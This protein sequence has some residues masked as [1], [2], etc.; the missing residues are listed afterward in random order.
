MSLLLFALEGRAQVSLTATSGTGTGSFTTLKAAFDAINAGTHQ[1][2]I[3]ISISANTTESAPCVLNSSGAGSASYTSVLVRPTNDGVTVSGSTATGRG[4]VELNGADNITIDGDNPNTGGTNKNLTITN[5]ATNTITYNSVIRIACGTAAPYLDN[6]NIAIKNL[7]LN[8]SATGRNGSGFT[9]TTASENTT[10]GIIVGPNGAATPTAITSITTAINASATVNSFQVDNNTINRVARGV[11]FL[12]NSATSS[13]SVTIT[14]N[15][16]GDQTALSGSAPYTSP[17]TTVYTKG[18]FV[19]GMTSLTISGNTIKNIISYVGTAKSAIELNTAVGTGVGTVAINNNIIEG[20]VSNGSSAADGILVSS[21]AVQAS[22]SGNSVTN[23]QTVGT[24]SAS[25]ITLSNSS[26]S[27]PSVTLNKNKIT[28]IYALNTGAYAARGILVSSGN[29]YVITNN[30]ISDLLA[31]NDNS[32]TS[33]TYA[34]KGISL[35]SGTGHKVYHNSVVLR[36]T[37]FG[38]LTTPDN[39]TCLMIGAA[40]Q[41][42]I[43]IRNNLF[44]NTI[45]NN[46]A[47][48]NACLQLP[49]GAT[50]SMNLTLNNNA[51]YTGSSSN[52]YL[53]IT[54]ATFNSFT[55]ANFN[56][57]SSSPATNARSYTSSLS[58]AGTNDNA[59]FAFTT[60][61]PVVSAS[62]LHLSTSSPTVLESGGA[63]VG[64]TEDIDGDVRP[65]PVGSANGGGTV[66]DIGSDEFDGIPSDVTPPIIS[67]TPLATT[68]LNASRTLTATI[69]DAS[70]VPTTGGDLPV[71][72]WKVN[73]GAY[74]SSQGVH[75]T[76][77][78][79][80]FSF[81]GGVSSLDTVSYYIVAQD[82]AGNVGAFPS[83]GASGLSISPPT[84]AIAPTN[85]SSYVIGQNLSGTYTVGSGG[86][87][88]TLTAAV[89]AYNGN[90]LS[91]P[92]VFSLTDATYSSAETFPITINENSFASLTNTLTIVP[93]TGVN[94]TVTSSIASPLFILN[95]SD[96]VIFEG[97]NNSSSS[98]NL[99]FYN[100]SASSPTL[101]Q[102][103]SLGANAGAT[104]N[105]VKNTILRTAVNST[106]GYGIAIGGST[107]GTSGS[108]N[109]NNTIQNNLIEEPVIGIYAIGDAANSSTG[110]DNL[111]VSQNTITANG[112]LTGYM[113]MRIG[114]ALSADINRNTIS[115]QT[116]GASLCGISLETGFIN[117]SV[118]RNLIS[119][120]QTTN[121][122]SIPVVRG[123]S[124]ATGSGSSNVTIA[125][126]V[127]SNVISFYATTNLGSNPCGILVGASGINTTYTNLTGGVNIDYNSINMFGTVDRSSACLNFGVFFGSNVSN[128]NFRNNVVSNAI[129]NGNASAGASKSF[130]IYSQSANT[131]F[132]AMDNNCFFVSGAQGVLGFLGSDAAAITDIRSL[133]GQNLNSINSNPLFNSN[134][135]LRPI[136]G[137]PLLGAG[138]PIVGLSVDYLGGSRSATAPSIGAYE[139]GADATAPVI[140]YSGIANTQSTSNQTVSATITDSG[141]GASGVDISTSN[142]PAIYF[143]KHSDANA[144]GVA[145]NSTG[146]G[147]KYKQTTSTSSPFSLE[148]DGSL[149]QSAPTA[150]DTIFYFVVAQ[151]S[152]G[153][154]AAE[155]S[156][157]FAATSVTSVTAAPTTLS[158]YIIVGPPLAGTYTVGTGGNFTTITE[159]VNNLNLRGVSAA[160]VFELTDALYS[161]GETFPIVLSNYTGI[162]ASNTVTILPAAANS[163]AEIS[164][165]NATAIF[166]FDNG[167]YYTLDGRPGGTGSTS[168]LTIS[169]A[170]TNAPTIRF[171]NDAS[172]NVVKFAAIKGASTSSTSGVVV[173]GTT[174]QTDG[175]DANTISNNSISNS[176]G[177]N[178]YN[179]IYSAGTA[180]KTNSGNTIS[181]N[182][183]SDFFNASGANAIAISSN[184]TGFSITGNSIYQSATR[185]VGG[186]FRGIS[187]DNTSG[188]NF[189]VSNNYIGGSAPLA[190]G[191][192]MTFASAAT[193]FQGIYI[194]A[195]TSVASSVQGNTIQNINITTTSTSTVQGLIYLNAGRFNVGTITANTLGSTSATGSIL[196]ST[197]GS[198]GTFAAIGLGTSNF[199]EVNISNN[200]IGG[201]EFSGTGNMSLRGIDLAGSTGRF[202]VSNNLIGS[203]TIANSLSQGTNNSLIGIINRNS[204]ATQP[205]VISNNTIA[206]GTITLATGA[207]TIRGITSGTPNLQIT[208]NTIYNLSSN[209]A[210]TSTGQSS[211]VIGI[212]HSA[213]GTNGQTCSGNT[214]HSLSSTA[215][216]AVSVIGIHANTA[217]SG[218]NVFHKN[219]I[220]SLSATNASSRVIGI[221]MAGGNANYYNNFI[222]LGIDAS[223]SAVT[224]S[225]RFFGFNETSGTNNVYFN[226][227]YIGGSGVGSG[228]DSTL[229]FTSSVT[230]VTREIRN[231]YFYN[232]RTNGSGTGIHYA[233]QVGGTSINPTGLTL[234]NN[235][236]YV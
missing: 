14:N 147:W 36:G 115:I 97:S 145:N 150:G 34:V 94:A 19:R 3:V 18:I 126:N 119:K 196:I 58:S 26:S 164:G 159:A 207:A 194:N 203:T 86:N 236:Y 87:Y 83:T 153:N 16:I 190:A 130:A 229:A 67:F 99:T 208:N 140:S 192:A 122:S 149:L 50:S 152:A 71:L 161:T 120:V 234:N 221:E 84:A 113:A 72:Y 187:I 180:A 235:N 174:T 91:G 27:V 68:C 135:N 33:T 219:N 132:T 56:S 111:V 222:R 127:I 191:T 46:A 166:S 53:L 1:G 133:F 137:S 48:A 65:G 214:I 85:P 123:I 10:F 37:F 173:F 162:S 211:A 80:E 146:N 28:Q 52:N 78:T 172:N 98:R 143:R 41:T 223:G 230:G 226:T 21:A 198:T 178:P 158:R 197:T 169:N 96:Y 103:R 217:T 213:T 15:T 232:E 106:T 45:V 182:N 11:V 95:G 35:A 163:A 125:N 9:S 148:I 82:N 101:I 220:H 139:S 57:T 227:V 224:S 90:C 118:T 136:F 193:V 225:V 142:K 167:D 231:N 151:D 30:W 43:D 12:G 17:S 88:S 51:Y 116:S 102:M 206:N 117:S 5:T 38:T 205:I 210:T 171:I 181:D 44:E 89:A 179:L 233:I 108:D 23:V 13:N 61:A 54:Q 69:S 79:F 31:V 42:G 156:A 228:N 176:T 121:T 75:V 170:N 7:I 209:N 4:L 22:V 107:L 199:A 218:T 73:G 201:I 32:T 6:N 200:Q 92:V 134:T 93:A 81:G 29:N 40:S 70:G 128:I 63:S 66:A 24:A 204:S 188:S 60:T 25:G 144:F 185:T 8:G 141:I 49:S 184:S 215:A 47:V 104:N 100:S 168:A 154:I 202:N 59:S 76:G 55:A 138:V 114:N 112:T 165:T 216:A 124:I 212:I 77:N 175:N 129:I 131:A 160:V 2:A 155:T 186:T 195:D 157:G 177:G 105:T 39:T 109:D 20:V 62:D 189:T 64:I 183:L 110:M 74:S